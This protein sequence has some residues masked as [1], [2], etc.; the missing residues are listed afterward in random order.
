MEF[1]TLEQLRSLGIAC[2]D[3]LHIAPET[4]LRG[5][6][7][8][9]L[10]LRNFFREREHQQGHAL[11]VSYADSTFE[12][13]E[14]SSIAIAGHHECVQ[15]RVCELMS[16]AP[17]RSISVHHSAANGRIG[18]LLRRMPPL[19]VAL[20]MSSGAPTVESVALAGS[21]QPVVPSFLDDFDDEL[22]SPSRGLGDAIAAPMVRASTV[23]AWAGPL[24]WSLGKV[25]CQRSANARYEA[26]V[27]DQDDWVKVTWAVDDGAALIR[28]AAEAA[29]ALARHEEGPCTVRVA[30]E[31][32]F[33]CP[34]PP[35]S[36]S[37]ST[38]VVQAMGNGEDSMPHQPGDLRSAIV[39]GACVIRDSQSSHTTG[40]RTG[41]R[42][43]PAR[44]CVR[45]GR[46][47]DT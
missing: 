22:S 1:A 26:V 3:A 31:C 41:D 2:A 33:G 25:Y 9:E 47:L 36:L 45:T 39:I 6:E 37:A 16:A 18:L 12:D 14:N 10:R 19:L 21:A 27:E 35:A 44:T 20:R 24:I 13:Y 4:P 5:L 43:R 11:V 46:G 42:H 38:T 7:G 34:P 30:L 15:R 32:V 28:V 23:Q 17:S 8:V 40:T 29:S